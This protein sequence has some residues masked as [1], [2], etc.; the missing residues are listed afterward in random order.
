MIAA[1]FRLFSVPC[2]WEAG[3][4]FESGPA[5]PNSLLLLM[6]YLLT[7]SSNIIRM[8]E[9]IQSSSIKGIRREDEDTE[10]AFFFAISMQ[11]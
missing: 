10:K 6:R 3:G 2:R 7:V 5:S 11:F 8:S 4:Q 1:I 9:N